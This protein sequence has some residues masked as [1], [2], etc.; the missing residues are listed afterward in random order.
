MPEKPDIRPLGPLGDLLHLAKTALARAQG[1][2]LPPRPLL[3][4]ARRQPLLASRK[5]PPRIHRTGQ[6]SCACLLKCPAEPRCQ[7][8]A[9]PSARERTAEKV[10]GANL[11]AQDP[12]WQ[13]RDAGRQALSRVC[14]GQDTPA[15]GGPASSPH[16]QRCSD[17]SP[18]TQVDPVG[19]ADPILLSQTHADPCLFSLAPKSWLP[20][21][22]P[23]NLPSTRFPM[24]G[25]RMGWSALE[26]RDRLTEGAPGSL[27]LTRTELSPRQTNGKVKPTGPTD[28]GATRQSDPIQRGF[29]V[30]MGVRQ[31]DKGKCHWRV[32]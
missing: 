8:A 32:T 23:L 2:S 29:R 17:N 19:P 3:P 18:R 9:G 10:A 21:A 14:T 24:M 22:A 28:R 30:P 27:T 6:D 16:Q 4:R 26:K 5:L 7:D 1:E 31:N 25:Q 12:W 13:R 11:T 20:S 15:P